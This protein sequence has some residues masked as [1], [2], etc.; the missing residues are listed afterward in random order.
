M[1]YDRVH[2]KGSASILVEYIY[3]PALLE[4]KVNWKPNAGLMLALCPISHKGG[5]ALCVS[6]STG[7]IFS[8][9]KEFPA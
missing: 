2:S 8:K 7:K 6:E 5:G 1:L 3:V 9:E 4:G